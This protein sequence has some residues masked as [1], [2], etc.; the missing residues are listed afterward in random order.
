MPTTIIGPTAADFPT[1]VFAPIIQSAADWEADWQT[2]PELELVGCS[3]HAGHGGREQ[4]TFRRRYGR[5]KQTWET[6][7]RTRDPQAV[8]EGVWIRVLICY[9]QQWEQI[10]IGRV[11]GLSSEVLG[12]DVAP[13]GTQSWT[14]YGAGRMLEKIAVSESYWYTG[15]FGPTHIGWVPKLN[16]RDRKGVILGNRSTAKDVNSYLFGGKSTWTHYD[17]V[18]YLLDR[19]VNAAGG[20]VWTIGGQASILAGLSEPIEPQATSTVAELLRVLIPPKLGIDY[21]IRPTDAG[22]EI[23]VFALL[24][25]ASSFGAAMLPANPNRVEAT[26]GQTTDHLKTEVVETHEHRYNRIRVLGERIV[27]CTS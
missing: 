9:E 17:Y 27:V 10:W 12:E 22:F 4:C 5:I 16:E 24:D 1:R 19:F 21:A 13:T 7:F 2:E 8:N 25:A 23:Y 26:I 11:E 15:G 14:A 6:T 20:P 18:E 3:V